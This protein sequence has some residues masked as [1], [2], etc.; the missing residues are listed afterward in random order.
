ML[1]DRVKDSP[2]YEIFDAVSKK[3]AAGE[4]VYSLAIGEPSFDTP[5]E[6]IDAATKSMKRG[7]VHYSSS[8]GTAQVRE[9]IRYKVRH[10]NGISA[11]IENTIFMTTKL[12]VFVA[13]ASVPGEKYEA[14][15][16]DPGYYYSEPVVLA[17]GTPVRYNLAEDF[18][19]DADQVKKRTSPLT[20]V[21]V[22]NTP[23]NPTGKVFD[24][25][26]LEELFEFCTDKGIFIISD[27]SYEDLVY[28]KRHWSIGSFEKT[29]N[30]VI[31]VFSLSKSYA[32]TGWRAGYVVAS[33]NIVQ[34]MNRFLENTMTC[35]PQFIQSASAFALLNG[36]KYIARF[37]AELRKRRNLLQ[38]KMSRIPSLEYEET[39][40]AFYSFPKFSLPI[41]ST[42]LSKRLLDEHN[43]A[44][45]PGVLFG[46]S[47]ERHL[48]ISFAS[49]PNVIE[50]GMKR[51]GTFLAGSAAGRR[52]GRG[53]QSVGR[54]TTPSS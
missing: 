37:R 29:P 30:L 39:E 31:S 49:P 33:E 14:L 2:A 32:M 35:F 47:G 5:A 50:E 28:E 12:G 1:I 48:R 4:E 3:R 26:Q 24:K 20:R 22:L 53:H 40:G 43:V 17:G 15:V 45:L 6:I 44:I 34:R 16:P 52:Y 25:S 51:L 36:D 8:Y 42:E 10:K 9:A 54:G 13:L 7:E 46:P 21:I 41:P 27:E 11:D 19:L 38:E 23:S 18:S